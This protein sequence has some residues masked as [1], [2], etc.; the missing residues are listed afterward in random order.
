[1]TTPA[2]SGAMTPAAAA[3]AD[4][5]L[6]GRTLA[7]C[8]ETDLTSAATSTMVA[9]IHAWVA[10]ILPS[11]AYP[12]VEGL[13]LAYQAENAL[14]ELHGTEMVN[15]KSGTPWKAVPDDVRLDAYRFACKL[16]AA[17]AIDLRYSY[18]SK[19][20]Y[21]ELTAGA[22]KGAVPASHKAA[23]KTVFR[24]SIV[25]HL[26][27]HAPALVVFDKHKNNPGPTL[28]PLPGCNH[29]V[30]GGIVRAAS[31]DVPGVQLADVAAYAVGRYLRR[32]DAIIDA[33]VNAVDAINMAML[34]GLSGRFHYL[35]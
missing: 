35:D 16:I 12:E 26:A 11:D 10:L 1:M 5:T 3:L 28:E 25:S 30:G 24:K 19:G 15:P 20:Q 13:V 2:P 27:R 4:R 32:R 7:F 23:V 6:P 9:D 21:A 18:I 31:H 14:P 29:L 17:H 34:E 22:P 33:T 8:D